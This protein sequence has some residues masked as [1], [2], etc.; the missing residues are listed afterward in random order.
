VGSPVIIIVSK[1]VVEIEFSTR[2]EKLKVLK[3]AGVVCVMFIHSKTVKIVSLLYRGVGRDTILTVLLSH[4]A[5]ASSVTFSINTVS[6]LVE[7]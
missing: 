4:N 5:P 3:Q 1:K 6:T 7:K 2:I